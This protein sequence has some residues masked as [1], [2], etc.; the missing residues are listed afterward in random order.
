MVSACWFK[1]GISPAAGGVSVGPEA[2]TVLIP[3]ILCTK[4]SGIHKIQRT[5]PVSVSF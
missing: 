3:L 1:P 2:N 5:D 4:I